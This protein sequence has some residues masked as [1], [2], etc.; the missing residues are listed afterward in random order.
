MTTV[1][2]RLVW[3]DIC[4]YGDLLPERG[5]CAL[6]RGEQVA[7]FRLHDGTLHA[8]G[9]Y[10]PAG[11]A[12]VLSRGIVGSRGNTPTVASPLYKQVYDLTT[13]QCLDDGAY[14]VP[15]VPVRVTAGRVEL[16][17]PRSAM[18]E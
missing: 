9:N 2:D 11:G 7:V 5:V 4:A 6:V 16:G 18:S 3:T 10:D 12:Y 13:G 8:V 14:A 17:T 1:V 15:V